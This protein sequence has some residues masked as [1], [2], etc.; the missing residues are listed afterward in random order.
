MRSGVEAGAIEDKKQGV[1]EAPDSWAWGDFSAFFQRK[2]DWYA[3]KSRLSDGLKQ[4]SEES[5]S[6]GAREG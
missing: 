3:G 4:R 6:S 1:S 2:R 5:L